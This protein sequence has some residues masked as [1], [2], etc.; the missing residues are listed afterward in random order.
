MKGYPGGVQ[1]QSNHIFHQRHTKRIGSPRFLEPF[2]MTGQLQVLNHGFFYDGL[3]IGGTEQFTLYRGSLRH[4]ELSVPGN[5]PFPL[6][7]LRLLKQF[8]VGN[9]LKGRY[10]NQDTLGCAQKNIRIAHRLRISEEAYFPVLYLTDL[11][12]EIRDFSFQHRFKSK[13]AWTG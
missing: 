9:C 4:P 8:I 6:H 5:E 10:L 13:M 7:C 3:N 2:L 11:V 12:P 1:I